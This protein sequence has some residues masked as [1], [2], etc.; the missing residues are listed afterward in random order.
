[1]DLD[2]VAATTMLVAQPTPDAAHWRPHCT[3]V[4]PHPLFPHGAKHFLHP[5][6]HLRPG[7]DVVIPGLPFPLRAPQSQTNS[8]DPTGR[9]V[10]R[11]ASVMAARILKHEGRQK[12]GVA[13]EL[14]CG[15]AAIP[16]T[17]AAFC[18][19]ETYATDMPEMVSASSQALEDHLRNGGFAGSV[20]A[21][22]LSWGRTAAK[23]FARVH[24]R[25]ELVIASECLY[26]LKA[27][28]LRVAAAT[29][30][31]LA[32]TIYELLSMHGVCLVLYNPRSD[33]EAYFWD[34]LPRFNLR[35]RAELSLD[36]LGF[37]PNRVDGLKLYAVE[38]ADAAP[39]S[40]MFRPI[41]VSLP[42]TAVE[43]VLD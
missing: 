27:T 35:R 19:F 32:S 15:A 40:P 13:I 39:P 31:A 12:R 20:R 37:S 18:G 17:C 11:G 8:G 30:E 7:V 43:D 38:R 22:P 2:A 33:V 42:T 29:M 26:A 23:E 4:I 6:E 5:C 25:A 24:G 3:S 41:L 9:A 28:D 36:D 34:A 21:A 16:A 10:W 1:M 14:G